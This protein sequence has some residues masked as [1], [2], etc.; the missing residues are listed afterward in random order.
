MEARNEPKFPVVNL[1]HSCTVL[2]FVC[3]N[4]DL[5]LMF[6]TTVPIS[7]GTVQ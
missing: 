1:L 4:G 7:K 5:L 2:R 6:Q 3:G